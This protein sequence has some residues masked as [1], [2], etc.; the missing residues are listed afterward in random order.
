MTH[1]RR[2]GYWSGKGGGGGSER[3]GR[4]QEGFRVGGEGQEGF[5]I[6]GEGAGSVGSWWGRDRRSLEWVRKAREWFR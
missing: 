4:G 3:V 6:G 5:G 2:A 1:S